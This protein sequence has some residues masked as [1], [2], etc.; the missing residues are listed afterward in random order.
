MDLNV[1]LELEQLVKSP[2]LVSFNELVNE[3]FHLCQARCTSSDE[4]I[5]NSDQTLK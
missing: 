3:I 4:T 1:Y 2:S 5:K